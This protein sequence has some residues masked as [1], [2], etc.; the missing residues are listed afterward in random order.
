MKYKKIRLE[1]EIKMKKEEGECM[2][3]KN[4]VNKDELIDI[5][6]LWCH[7]TPSIEEYLEKH[8]WN[9]KY[10]NMTWL[11]F[12]EEYLVCQECYKELEFNLTTGEP[13]RW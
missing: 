5:G 3:C 9:I 10:W 6:A 13:Y 11:R 8:G 4:V 2:L 1:K 12:P 7:I